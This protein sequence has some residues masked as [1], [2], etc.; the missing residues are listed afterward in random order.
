MLDFRKVPKKFLNITLIDG[1]AI[2]V[3]MPTKKIFDILVTLENNLSALELN[4]KEQ[5]AYIYDLTAEILSNNLKNE[6]IDSDYLAG[7]LDV[8][9]IQILFKSYV[10]FVTGFTNVPNSAS[11]QSQEKE[12]EG[13]SITD[14]QQS[15]ND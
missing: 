5:I 1:K 6:K 2:L 12:M 3:R 13:N 7:L 10:N 15:G 8:E 9:D 4:N 11:P 14:A